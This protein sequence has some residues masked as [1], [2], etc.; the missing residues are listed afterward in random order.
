[1]TGFIY[2]FGHGN[3]NL[4]YPCPFDQSGSCTDSVFC[5]SFCPKDPDCYMQYAVGDD[6]NISA[7]E[8]VC[9]VNCEWNQWFDD[10]TNSCEACDPACVAVGCTTAGVNCP[11][12]TD[13][14]CSNCPDFEICDGCVPN[15]TLI[16]DTC[17][18]NPGFYLADDGQ[19]CDQCH[20]ACAECTDNTDIAC[21]SCKDG[22]YK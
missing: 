8:N 10:T 15:A 12:C 17:V 2:H 16:D 3:N 4:S 20:L 7:C 14:T 21:S 22:W 6:T 1:L 18:C 5:S 9:L 11:R 19:S 13:D